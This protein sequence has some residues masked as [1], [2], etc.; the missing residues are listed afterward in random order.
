MKIY[1]HDAGEE[2]ADVNKDDLKFGG[3][4][5]GLKANRTED[6]RILLFRPELNALR[7]KM[8]AERL[9]MPSPSTQQFTDSI[10]Q[11]VLANKRWV[12][13]FSLRTL[14]FWN[15]QFNYL[16]FDMIAPGVLQFNYLVFDMIA[17]GV[18]Q[19]NY[20][21]RSILIPKLSI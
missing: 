9:C 7:M 8:G 15:L 1:S 14:H 13:T 20:F 16:V 3:L 6:G 18:L 21:Y 12:L 5:E 11:T 10:E 4:Y 19:F 2:Y 17:P